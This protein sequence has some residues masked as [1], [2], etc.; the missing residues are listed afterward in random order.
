[1]NDLLI[2]QLAEICIIMQS[3]FTQPYSI[4]GII[5]CQAA[6]IVILYVSAESWN[7]QNI[8][9]EMVQGDSVRRTVRLTNCRGTTRSFLLLQ[10]FRKNRGIV[11]NG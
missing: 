11:S 6:V 10:A 7:M 8:S 3:L 4:P 1:M 2:F 5:S 9:E